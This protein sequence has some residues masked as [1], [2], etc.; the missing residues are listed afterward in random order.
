MF[1]IVS[2]KCG[3][4][5][6]GIGGKLGFSCRETRDVVLLPE[7]IKYD[8]VL[9]AHAPSEV[10]V[11]VSPHVAVA[12]AG[13]AMFYGNP[14]VAFWVNDHMIGRITQACTQTPWV[15]IPPGRY[16]LRTQVEGDGNIRKHTVWIFRASE[17][18][19]T[20]RLALVTI[21]C[22]P[23]KSLAGKLRW[24][25]AS[26]AA[27][28]ILV[29]VTGVNEAYGNHFT[30]KIERLFEAIQ[31]LPSCYSHVV[32][33]DGVDTFVLAGESEIKTK[34]DSLGSAVIGT[35]ACCW[36]CRAPEWKDSLAALAPDVR[37]RYP[38]AGTWGGRIDGND[39]I[40]AA[41]LAVERLHYA[42]KNRRGPEWI[43]KNGRP[44]ASLWDDQFCWH[45]LVRSGY[46][47]LFVDYH[48]EAFA[49]LTCTNVD[50][51]NTERFFVRDGRIVTRKGAQPFAAHLSGGGKQR[52]GLWA[53]FIGVDHVQ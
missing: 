3:H 52:M 33:L 46:R 12:G 31:A 9:S 1:T 35:E 8:Q 28:G 22:Y 38:N 48:W 26:A 41:L 37:E 47:E 45:A 40:L 7:R 5:K 50:P 20:G 21:G 19:P 24:L 30:R 15:H 4:G 2:E 34:L 53:N 27:R 17:L 44:L 23:E 29:H 16:R 51:Q 32:Y 42:S 6:A 13:H 25:Y 43:Y 11:D 39:G 49:N 14:P 18:P 36:P 10:V